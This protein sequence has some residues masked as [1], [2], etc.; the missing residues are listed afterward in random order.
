[1]FLKRTDLGLKDS[2][3][4]GTLSNMVSA[5]YRDFYGNFAHREILFIVTPIY[6]HII[7]L[8]WHVTI[9]VE[10][11]LIKVPMLIA[12]ITRL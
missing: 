5:N 8:L 10:F 1:M 2:A 4:I 7:H 11:T 3:Q 6:C 9:D 12:Q